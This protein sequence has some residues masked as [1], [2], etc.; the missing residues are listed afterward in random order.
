MEVFYEKIFEEKS[1][2]LALKETMN[3]FQRC[4]PYTSFLYW[5]AFQI[6]GEDVSFTK[7][8]IEEIRGNNKKIMASN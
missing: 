3:I 5:A 1:V 4:G 6:L 7:L 2:C 8:E